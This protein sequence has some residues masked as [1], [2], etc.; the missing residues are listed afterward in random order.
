MG[1][2]AAEMRAAVYR[3]ANRMALETVPVPEIGDRELLVRVHCLRRL[4]HRSQEDRTR[5]G[6]AAPDLRTR[7][8]GNGRAD[9][10]AGDQVRARR[11]RRRIPSRSLPALLLLP[12]RSCFRSATIYRRTGTT[13]GFEPAGGGFAAYV[14]VMDWIVE[15]GTIAIPDACELRG[16]QLP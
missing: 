8:C 14:R 9:R 2:S 1:D 13:A 4:R 6:G 15:G 3:G 12:A 5:P 7:D 10:E 11:P 16:S